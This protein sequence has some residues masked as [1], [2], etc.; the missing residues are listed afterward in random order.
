[1]TNDL[2][3]IALRALEPLAVD[4]FSKRVMQGAARVLE[5]RDNPLRLNLFATASRI[6]LEHLMGTLAPKAEVEQCWWYVAPEDTDGPTRAQRIRFC[7][8][9]G[10][11]DSF[12]IDEL[13]LDPRPLEARLIRAYGALSKHVHGREE[14]VIADANVQDREASAIVTAIGNFLTGY[15]DAR[16]QLIE[17]ISESLDSSAVDALLSETILSVDEL[18]SH[19]SVE[20]VYV[21]ETRVEAIGATSIRYRATGIVDVVLQW[22]SNSDLRNGDGA[23]SEQTFPFVCTFEVPVETPH[24]LDYAEVGWGVDTS[25]WRD[26]FGEDEDDERFGPGGQEIDHPDLSVSPDEDDLW[27]GPTMPH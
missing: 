14:T 3:V 19:H 1:M 15:W 4:D 12:V 5:D 9:G 24:E 16:A 6:F 8:R 23:E 13:G 26:M 25:S 2:P 27:C 22:G 20:D 17:P 11:A 10:L 7:L 18:A 21:H